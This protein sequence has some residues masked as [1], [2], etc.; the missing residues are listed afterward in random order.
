M[1]IF[2][3]FKMP[4]NALP[5]F[6][7]QRVLRGRYLFLDLDPPTTTELTVTCAGW[8][9]CAPGYEIKRDGFRYLALEYI[10]GGSWE[11]ETRGKKWKVGP[12]T[13]FTYGP[14]TSYSLKALSG[15]GFSKYFVDFAGHSAASLISKTGLKGAKPG[16]IVHRRWLHDLLEQLIETAQLSPGARSKLSKMLAPL[17]LERVR[18]DLRTGPNFSHAQLS[19]EQVRQYLIDHYLKIKSLSDAAHACGVSSAYLSRLFHRFATES[20]NQFLVRL[21]MNHAA[22]LIVRSSISVKEAAQSV[23]YD[24]PYHFSR[25]FKRVHGVAP[26]FFGK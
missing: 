15:G 1:D 25:V 14:T 3:L 5:N 24:D 16:C 26:S 20:P 9:E 8:E 19:Y 17:I 22:E 6:I 12:G 13:V 4:E 10:A 2:Y 21:K 23:G 18:V 11:L 7:S